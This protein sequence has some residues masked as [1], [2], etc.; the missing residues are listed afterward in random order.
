MDEPADWAELAA[1]ADFVWRTGDDLLLGFRRAVT[2][3]AG[4][5][6]ELAAQALRVL[7]AAHVEDPGRSGLGPVVVG[8][9]PFESGPG[10]LF[11]PER[12]VRRRADGYWETYCWSTDRLAP[13]REP[14]EPERERDESFFSPAGRRRWTRSAES[15]IRK[16]QAGELAKVVL[17]AVVTVPRPIGFS[18]AALFR[19]LLADT[20][21]GYLYGVGN[22]IG[23]SPELLVERQ[24]RQA[25]TRPMAGTVPLGGG[26]LGD[27]LR[28]PKFYI[29]H[30]LVVASL[31]ESL[32]G[33]G[34]VR[35]GETEA[36]PLAAYGHLAR[37]MTVELGAGHTPSALEIVQALH[38]TPAVG[39]F[40][41]LA[42]VAEIG[43]LEPVP[44][45]RYSGPVGWMDAAGNGT[46]AV[47]IRC[48]RIG[49]STVTVQAG[50]GLVADSEA[51]AECTEVTLKAMTLL[52]ALGQSQTAPLPASAPSSC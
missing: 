48:L 3:A 18:R 11:I 16:I 35:S 20:P 19:R 21:G 30:A 42:A 17:S 31:T 36:V 32:G 51:A 12:I 43:R 5:T 22:F 40:P 2:F 46:W 8:A 49:R 39:G 50:A 1:T 47:A 9:L 7:N 23:A 10:E 38:P 27:L 52:A 44:R 13:T 14:D 28:S 33:F 26:P 4:D 45:G 29:E 41:G 37:T 34:A 6:A 24:G 25:S 15:A